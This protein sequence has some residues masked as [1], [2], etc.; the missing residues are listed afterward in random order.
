MP[1][2]SKKLLASAEGQPCAYCGSIGTTVSAHSNSVALGKGMG[3]KCPDFYCAFLC[4][5]CHSNYDG[6][7]GHLSRA[8]K[9]EM[10]TTAYLRT[11]GQWF[12]QGFV[13]VA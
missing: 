4:V 6:R 5:T 3:I 11:V 10:W 7:S 9:Y 13:K 12:T 2:R 1:F 8:E